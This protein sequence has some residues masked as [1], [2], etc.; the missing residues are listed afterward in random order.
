MAK[1][2]FVPKTYVVKPYSRKE[3]CEL[4]ELS[5]YVLT[6]WLKAIEPKLGKPQAGVYNVAQVQLIINTYGLP[7]ELLVVEG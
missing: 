4:L 2:Q 6:Q 3:L 5:K 7:G 1:Y